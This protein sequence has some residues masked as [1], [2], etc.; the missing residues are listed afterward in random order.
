VTVI[1]VGYIDAY[2]PAGLVIA[3]VDTSGSGRVVLSLQVL[4]RSQP[5]TKNSYLLQG[6][7]SYLVAALV[8]GGEGCSAKN[9]AVTASTIP[10]AVET[11]YTHLFSPTC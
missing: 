7:T 4:A 2:R 8:P 9:R 11:H 6:A 3:E 10:R 5:S 1:E